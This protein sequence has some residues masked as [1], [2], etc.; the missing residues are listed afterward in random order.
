VSIKNDSNLMKLMGVDGIN[1]K[2]KYLLT[3]PT[4]AW[5]YWMCSINNSTEKEIPSASILWVVNAGG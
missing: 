3:R 5:S 2:P 4:V 1:Q